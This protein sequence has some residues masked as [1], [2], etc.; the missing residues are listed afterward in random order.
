MHN[1]SS[2]R[3][4]FK[5]SAEDL[6]VIDLGIYR[7]AKAFSKL[8]PDQ[9]RFV[10]M[11]GRLAGRSTIEAFNLPRVPRS[12]GAAVA[13]EA[14]IDLL[15]LYAS[16]AAASGV[17]GLFCLSYAEP[18][19]EK[20]KGK[21]AP[22]FH[23]QHF[24]A[25]DVAALAI[26]A[27]NRSATQNV[28]FDQNLRR[29]GTPS[30]TR[31]KFEDITASLS[32]VVEEDADQQKFL[33][34]PDG[35]KPTAIVRTSAIPAE[36]THLHF[37]FA[38]AISSQ[39]AKD[40][41]ELA[42]R[43]MGGDTGNKDV[44]K[45]WRVPGT[46]NHPD[47]R[48][49]E[50]G[51]PSIPQDVAVIGGTGLPVDPDELRKALEAMPDRYTRKAMPMQ[52]T[53]LANRKSVNGGGGNHH[54]GNTER[55]RLLA[56][57]AKINGL[58]DDINTEGQDESAQ[59]ARVSWRLFRAGFTAEEVAILA[60]GA[61]FSIKYDAD[62]RL[63]TEVVRSYDK[64][65][66]VQAEAA[67][68]AEA[69]EDS[70]TQKGKTGRT[71]AKDA[72]APG[73][74]RRSIGKIRWPDLTKDQTPKATSIANV[75][76]AFDHLGIHPWHNDFTNIP[77]IEGAAGRHVLDDHG[78]SEVWRRCNEIRFFAT[79]AFIAK[80]WKAL[81]RLDRRHPIRD[82]L[83]G[84]VWN[85]TKR[86]ERLF[87]DYAGAPDTPYNRALGILIGVAMVRRIRQPGYKFDHV[88]LLRGPQDIAKSL[89]WQTL[90]S[91]AYF[92][93]DFD[94]S[95]SSKEIIEQTAR[96]W[97]IEV[98]EMKG[99]TPKQIGHIRALITRQV[100]SSRLAYGVGMAQDFPRH[101]VVVG[102]INEHAILHDQH[103]NRRFDI[104]DVTKIDIEA[105][106]RDREQILAEA[107]VLEKTY[108]Y[109]VLPDAVKPDAKAMQDE[110]LVRDNMADDIEDALASRYGFVARDDIYD[111]VLT[112]TKTHSKRNDREIA[113]VI[114]ET[115]SR[116]GWKETQLNNARRTR[117]YARLG[118]DGEGKTEDRK[119]SPRWEKV[120][121][122]G[123]NKYAEDDEN[124]D[125][126]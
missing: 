54:T 108:G 70:G 40:L 122:N 73:D 89:F 120:I 26:E 42:Y 98:A 45:A 22:K 31:G 39:E 116:L 38:R 76:A 56:R 97:V 65:K 59:F 13:S 16:A 55:D 100:D 47:W 23:V 58:I 96:K 20:I 107:C 9:R 121:I 80:A 66:A 25:T 32:L 74:K 79:D 119:G 15:G 29:I 67:E 84:L 8:P 41:Q 24:K 72:K 99:M 101:F 57:C 82:W 18:Q 86:L 11:R 69:L 88:I 6:N 102:T 124:D 92:T 78:V 103:G 60:T 44:T 14:G 111:H 10:W 3:P 117:G 94:F 112:I 34:M 36:N 50:R 93:D 71:A 115:V 19:R 81:A 63:E 61:A 28:Y 62:G 43:K 95:L 77:E 114:K 46:K 35:I 87:I 113:R 51:R 85:G 90:A 27:K 109:L 7:F 64:W 52:P 123:F 83:D 5:I 126:A 91:P 4:A 125:F 37:V 105:L 48:K 106:K 21:T 49:I 2:K 110:A 53:G 1:I 12:M 68:A 75:K 104:I 17:Q 33:V 30:G 118:P